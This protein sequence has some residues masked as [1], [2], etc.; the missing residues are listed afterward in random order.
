MFKF[1]LVAL[2]TQAPSLLTPSE[3]LDIPLYCSHSNP[4]QSHAHTEIKKTFRPQPQEPG[5]IGPE[6]Q[7]LATADSSHRASRVLCI[8]ITRE[9]GVGVALRYLGEREERFTRSRGAGGWVVK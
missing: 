2:C 9:L 8:C 5:G 3:H 1:Q 7:E 6:G 4:A